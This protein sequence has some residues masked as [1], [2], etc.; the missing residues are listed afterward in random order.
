M[1]RENSRES[2]AAVFVTAPAAE[3]VLGSRRLV[4][5][6]WLLGVGLVVS[7]LVRMAVLGSQSSR[8]ESLRIGLVGRQQPRPCS[9]PSTGHVVISPDVGRYPP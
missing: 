9:A 3:L 6:D 4:H 5:S 7:V 8:G 1:M 2:L